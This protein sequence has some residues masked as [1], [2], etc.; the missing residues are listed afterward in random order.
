MMIFFDI[1][2]IY[3]E[4]IFFVIMMNVVKIGFFYFYVNKEILKMKKR[5]WCVVMIVEY[6]FIYLIFRLFFLIK[7]KMWRNVKNLRLKD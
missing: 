5:E 3:F 4:F 6:Y 7:C 1:F 2:K